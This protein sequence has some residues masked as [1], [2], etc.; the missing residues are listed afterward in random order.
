MQLEIIVAIVVVVVFIA[1]FAASRYRVAG[2][3]EA[4][5]ISGAKGASVRG[6][7]GK[8]VVTSDHDK[9][10]KVVVGGGAFVWPLINKVGKL[11]LAAR[12]VPITLD[13]QF[14]AV[15][16]QGIP[17]QVDGQV[18]FK[19]AHEPEK[20]RAAAERFLGEDNKINDMVMHVLTGSLRAISGTLTIEELISDRERFQQAVSEAARGDLEA[21]GIHIDALTVTSIKD[22]MGYID[23]LGKKNF[24]TVN[25]DQRIATATAD[26]EA[27]LRE[28]SAAQAIVNAKRDTS[29]VTADA[30]K[31]TA[32]R[33]AEA[34]QAGPLASAMAKQEVTSRQTQ[35]ATLEAARK[36]QELLATTVRPAEAARDAAIARAEGEKQA[37]IKGAEAIAARTELTGK[38]EGAAIFAR[39][40]AEAKAKDLLADA[41]AKYGQAAVI[42]TVFT[43][44]PAI[45]EAAA[46]PLGS[47]DSLTVIDSDGANKLTDTVGKTVASGNAMLK[48]LLGIDLGESLASLAKPSE[49]A[50]PTEPKK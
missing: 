11:S 43:L 10:I 38:A 15:T 4:L 45:V 5:I 31:I 25:R 39:G 47:I 17:I 40:E 3:N 26:Q 7:D 27:Q 8:M 48:S 21:A 30:T 12:Q 16:I 23:Q 37:T 34:D 50:K 1:F 24:A 36:Q 19:I 42:Q 41:Y 6:P 32:A 28:Q 44:M 35:L 9:G 46:R 49:T 22:T 18:M 20:L 29:V 2:A 33:Q 13:E 14:K